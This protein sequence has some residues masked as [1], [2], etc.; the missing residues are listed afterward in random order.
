MWQRRGKHLLKNIYIYEMRNKQRRGACALKEL[1]RV[2]GK[3]NNE[4]EL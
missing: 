1:E 3:E 2:H 4:K